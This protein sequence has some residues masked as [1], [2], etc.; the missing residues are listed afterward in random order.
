VLDECRR[1]LPFDTVCDVGCGAG[2]WLKA[3]LEAGATDVLGVDGEYARPSLLIPV[4]KFQGR[5]LRER[6][7]L[8]RAFDLVISLEV[9]EH[10]PR[11][12][13]ASFVEDLT[14]LAPA[15]LF[16]AAIPY[17][18]GTAHINERWQSFWAAEF[19]RY[20]FVLHDVIRPAIWDNADVELWYRQN[21]MLFLSSG[22]PQASA[23]RAAVPGLAMPV[24][25][26]HP[27][28]FPLGSNSD[29]RML[30]LKLFYWSLAS[31]MKRWLRR[32]RSALSVLYRP[33]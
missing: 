24:S 21:T 12:R 27:G 30:L 25:V 14:R 11:E 2:T 22:H 31:D 1:Y 26:V 15:V 17:Q 16:S 18:G 6:I 10:L 5:D 23:L 32:D 13:S 33:D 28:M 3:A 4:D 8:P 20:G 9:A 7:V 19:V 29:N